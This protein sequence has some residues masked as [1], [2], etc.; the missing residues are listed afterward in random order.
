M[1]KWPI[2]TTVKQLRSFLGLTGY[3]HRFIANYASIAAPLTDL[4][5]HEAFV[6]S[7]FAASAFTALKQAMIAAPVLSLP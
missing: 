5:R 2:P 7:D 4:L 6:W 1:V 3:Y